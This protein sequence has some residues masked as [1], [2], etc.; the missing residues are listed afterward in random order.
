MNTQFLKF[1]FVSGAIL[2]ANASFAAVLW[3][4]AISGD[5]SDDRLNPTAFTASA[6]SNTISGSSVAANDPFDGDRDYYSITVP[7]GME[8]YEIRLDSYVSDDF[9]LFTG[10]VNGP[11]FNVDPDN[12]NIS[13]ILGYWVG[14]T[15]NIGQD[16]L[17]D[18][19]T[20]G[21]AA[22]FT[23]ALQ[24]GTYSFWTQQTGDP[25]DYTFDYKVR[26][27]P[28]PASMLALSIGSALLIRRR[29]A[30]KA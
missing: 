2:V 18:M 5:L 17:P 19:G 1:S 24:A 29:N 30:R 6:G 14:G 15:F 27:V 20:A 13:D 22:G 28:E 16:I 3:S 11:V 10:V 23:G 25:T 9:A 26:V 8:M 12:I 4:E 21:G 7:T